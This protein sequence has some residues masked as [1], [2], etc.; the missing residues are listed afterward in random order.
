MELSGADKK[1]ISKQS[2]DNQVHQYFDNV[3]PFNF[4]V[5]DYLIR[6]IRD[7]DINYNKPK[8]DWRNVKIH[9]K[10]KMNK[11][12]RVVH[13]DN[14]GVPYVKHIKVNGSLGGIVCMASMNFQVS[15]FEPDPEHM[16]H[17]ILDMQS[18]FDPLQTHKEGKK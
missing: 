18:E 13:I 7:W 4:K 17:I 8:G 5:G 15:R 11:K 6:K 10:S 2:R 14:H 1:F 12:F 16:E 9:P 3:I